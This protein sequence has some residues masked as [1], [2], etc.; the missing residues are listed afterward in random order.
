MTNLS[1]FDYKNHVIS[2]HGIFKILSEKHCIKSIIVILLNLKSKNYMYLLFLTVFLVFKVSSK[3]SLSD[4]LQSF[5][6]SRLF[7][8]AILFRFCIHFRFSCKISISLLSCVSFDPFFHRSF[9]HFWI[10][11]SCDYFLF[12]AR[13]I[14]VS[15]CKFSHHSILVFHATRVINS[16]SINQSPFLARNF[17]TRQLG[18]VWCR[19]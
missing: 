3:L 13:S 1:V 14:S 2:N 4:H 18:I 5:F 15:A 12:R 6:V 17:L 9:Y 7:Y 16:C 19:K 11:D 10:M 8:L